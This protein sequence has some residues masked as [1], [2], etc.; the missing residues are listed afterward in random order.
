MNQDKR[1]ISFRVTGKVQGVWFRVYT[2]DKALLLNVTGWVKN[3][4]DGSVSG[5]AIGTID[6]IELLIENLKNGSP[7]SFVK[8]V[9]V[10]ENPISQIVDGFEIKT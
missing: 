9:D 8:D 4:D 3:N 1:Y 6:N 7:N 2:R 5:E 10:K